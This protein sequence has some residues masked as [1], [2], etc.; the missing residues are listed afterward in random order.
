M[1]FDT[2]QCCVYKSMYSE[3]QQAEMQHY[4]VLVLAICG[5]YVHM[6]V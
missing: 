5:L 2:R 3:F 1:L 6:Q 4:Q